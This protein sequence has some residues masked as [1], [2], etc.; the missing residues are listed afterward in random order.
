MPEVSIIVPV[1]NVEAYLEKCIISILNQSFSDFELILVDD[2]SPDHA[3][4][5][6]DQYM[7]K[8][9]RIKTI[10]KKNGGLSDARNAG[11]EIAEGQYLTFIDSDDFVEP[12]YLSYLI[13][14]INLSESCKI[15]QANHYVERNGKS[16]PEAQLESEVLYSRKEAFENV[17]YHDQVNVSGWGKLFHRS[18]FDELRFPKGK[19]FEDTYLFGEVLLKTE[20]YAFG[21]KP[22]YHYIQ[23]GD[24]IVN[25]QFSEKNLMFIEA[26]K[27][28]T[29]IARREYP[30]LEH[31]CI[32][33][34]THSYLNVLRYM[35]KCSLDQ[36]PL[37]D[38]LRKK[39]LAQADQV[40]M[41][42]RT[43]RRDIIALKLLKMGY[44]PFYK[45]WAI[46]NLLR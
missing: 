4:L 19:L 32:R 21:G 26:V 45:S 38:D 7:E 30:D 35:E 10:H 15:S 34:T 18:V 3:G 13:K 42:P 12:S 40:C 9:D 20:K 16:K 39:A 22:Q 36:R 46:Y 41:D 43:P 2:G 6:C 25:Q 28:L 5:I 33:R 8:D 14:L 44:L 23:R 37:R 29:G 17:L 27:H 1:Y 11:I 24:S 31:A